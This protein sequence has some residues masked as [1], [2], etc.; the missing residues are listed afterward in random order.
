MFRVG[1]KKKIEIQKFVFFYQTTKQRCQVLQKFWNGR[2]IITT[3]KDNCITLTASDYCVQTHIVCLIEPKCTVVLLI[4]ELKLTQHL[5]IPDRNWIL[6]SRN[7]ECI[8]ACSSWFY[9]CHTVTKGKM[10]YSRKCLYEIVGFHC[11]TSVCCQISCENAMYKI[12]Q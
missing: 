1:Q 8:L 12:I 3:F 11:I 10:W 9:I 6:F 7:L 4:H 2:H 5:G